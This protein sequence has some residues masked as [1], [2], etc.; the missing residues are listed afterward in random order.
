MSRPGPVSRLAAFRQDGRG[1]MAVEFALLLP[2]LF[3]LLFGGIDV[4]EG[5]MA[6]RKVTLASNTVSDLV[7]QQDVI[8]KTDAANILTAASAV[9]TPFDASKMSAVVTSVS[10]DAQGAATVAW[11]IAKNAAP[12]AKG[13]PYALPNGLKVPSTS[14][15]VSEVGYTYVP[16]I[17]YAVVGDIPLKGKSYAHP[18]LGAAVK[19]TADG[20]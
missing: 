3:L 10:V 5:V 6:K 7:A 1:A 15:V 14:V 12:R 2:M 11:S 16:A 9:L 4:T 8:D 19:C 20:C 18:R 17:G 13:T